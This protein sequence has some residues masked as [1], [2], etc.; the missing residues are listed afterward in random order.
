MIPV[1]NNSPS[2]LHASPL[3]AVPSLHHQCY[4]HLLLMQ[5]QSTLYN[6]STTSTRVISTRVLTSAE[7]L[8]VKRKKR[9]KKK[10]ES[11]KVKKKKGKEELV[12]KKADH[13]QDNQDGPGPLTK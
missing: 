9:R 3:L 7:G 11:R 4:L 12:K 2:P 10:E 5:F 13:Y 8:D 1:S 6:M